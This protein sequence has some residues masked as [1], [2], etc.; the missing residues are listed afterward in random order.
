MKYVSTRGDATPRSF[1]SILLE[2]LAPDGGLYLPT[3]YP[4]L[5]AQTLARWRA[6]PYAELA[7]QVMA[8]FIDD[9]PVADVHALAVKT[10]TAQVFGS[11]QIA[12]LRRSCLH[13]TRIPA[14]LLQ[15]RRLRIALHQVERVGE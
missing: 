11:P 7:A 12:P 6:L 9:M 13:G 15:I 5:S 8:L 14:L 10:Y 4:Q 1:C 2:G 3:H